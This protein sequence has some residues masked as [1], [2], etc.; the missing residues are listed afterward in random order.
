MQFSTCFLLSSF[1]VFNFR[2][3]RPATYNV[4][5]I[6][7]KNRIPM[8]ASPMNNR[9]VLP[10]RMPIKEFHSVSKTP[11]YSPE[12]KPELV[13][14]PATHRGGIDDDKGPI[15][16]IPAPNLSPA[17]KPFNSAIESAKEIAN[18]RPAYSSDLNYRTSVQSESIFFITLKPTA[19]RTVKIQVP[20]NRERV[21]FFA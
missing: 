20:I 15:H 18:R 6:N 5:P 1:R 14:L 4:S 3:R 9:V 17:D 8:R 12:Y 11:E 19:P 21:Y 13:I 10:Q 2:I 16:T 7:W